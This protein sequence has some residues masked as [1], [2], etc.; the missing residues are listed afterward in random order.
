MHGMHIAGRM[1]LDSGK[2]LF[3]ILVCFSARAADIRLFHL[4]KRF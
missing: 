4:E 3:A 2:S 1:N